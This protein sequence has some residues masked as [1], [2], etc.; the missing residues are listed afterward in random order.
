MTSHMTKAPFL[1][2]CD[3][4]Q[5]CGFMFGF[6]IAVVMLILAKQLASCTAF[7]IGR[8]LGHSKAFRQSLENRKH[9]AAFLRAM[10]HHPWRV[11]LL[12]R[13]IF[14]PIAGELSTRASQGWTARF[15]LRSL[16]HAPTSRT[17]GLTDTAIRHSLRASNSPRLG[18]AVKNYGLSLL[19]CPFLVFFFCT[20]LVSA[21]YSPLFSQIGASSASLLDTLRGG[22][23]GGHKSRL[24][25]GLMVS[26]LVLTVVVLLLLRYFT[27]KVSQR[28]PMTDA[29]FMHRARGIQMWPKPPAVSTWPLPFA[30]SVGV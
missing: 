27:K 17:T 15:L 14:M 1:C 8:A 18:S 28:P 10:E 30:S 2:V 4:P 19:P 22:N 5:A 20:L 29:P 11:T 23:K 7:G 9:A 26:E 24:S 3:D 13:L 25:M 6:R 16:P 12:L 21:V